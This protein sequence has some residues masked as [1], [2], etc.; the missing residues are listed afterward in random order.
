MGPK[1]MEGRSDEEIAVIREFEQEYDE[2]QQ[3]NEE[4]VA[5]EQE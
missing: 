1:W 3:E 4:P 5:E 2:S